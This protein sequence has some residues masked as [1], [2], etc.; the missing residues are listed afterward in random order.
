M[1]TL[2]KTD[3]TA[4]RLS[5][6][7][8]NKPVDPEKFFNC[9]AGM[10]GSSSEAEL[11]PDRGDDKP[12]AALPRPQ[13]IPRSVSTPSHQ[14]S[15]PNSI[16]LSQMCAPATPEA[17]G[18]LAKADSQNSGGCVHRRRLDRLQQRRCLKSSCGMHC[19]ASKSETLRLRPGDPSCKPADR[20]SISGS[21]ILQPRDCMQYVV[22]MAMLL[23]HRMSRGLLA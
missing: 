4:E 22:S 3:E 18:R 6:T 9:I 7:A 17:D 16:D 13:M 5:L 2:D 1:C 8:I 14:V 11:A 19:T 10:Q 12:P 20:V 15:L 23:K 21:T